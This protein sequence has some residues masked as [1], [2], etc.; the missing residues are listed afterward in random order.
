MKNTICTVFGMIGAA[1]SAIFG[2]W[3]SA[4]ILL[5]IAMCI[6]YISGIIVA[7]IFHTSRK[8]ESG[9]LE[10][11]AGWKGLCRKGMTL[12]IVL[13]CHWVDLV[14]G[15]NYIRDAAVIGFIVNEIISITE[16]AGLMGVPMPSIVKKAIDILTTMSNG[17]GDN[18][19][20]DTSDT[21]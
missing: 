19:N 9:A 8:S 7:G 20:A 13:V 11:Y 10:S 17:K 16:N 3:D 4:M 14:I 2:G 21:E 5:V 6:D 18:D 12:M 1:I 15:V